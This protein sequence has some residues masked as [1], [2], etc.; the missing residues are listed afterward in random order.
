MKHSFT[1]LSA[2]G[3]ALVGAV[4]LLAA[5]CN[6]DNKNSSPTP[7]NGTGGSAATGGAPSDATGGGGGDTSVTGTGGAPS[8][9]ATGGAA[10]T[11]GAPG[12]GGASS[13]STAPCTHDPTK[14][15]YECTPTTN[16]QILAAC[17]NATCYPFDNTARGVPATLPAIP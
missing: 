5:A 16:D 14:T 12:V 2:F 1:R 17:S 13:T 3:L 8:T 4:A 10:A 15:C 7:T 9:D 11:G 6:S